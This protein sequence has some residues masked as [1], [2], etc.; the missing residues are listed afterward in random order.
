MPAFVNP[1]V[2][3]EPAEGANDALLNREFGFPA[4]GL[5]FF[6]IEEDEGVVADPAFVAAGVFDFRRHAE[7]GADVADALVDLH[8]FGRA[9]IVDLRVVLGVAGG[10]L[11]RD[12]ED[13]VYAVLDV[14]VALALGAVAQDAKVAR[15][16]E[17]L[18]VKIENVAVRVALAEDGDEPENVGFVDLAT[19]SVGGDQALAGDFAGTVERGLDREK[20]S[21]R[22]GA[23]WG[24]EGFAVSGAGRG[25]TDAFNAVGAHGF[26]DVESSNGVLLEVFAGMLP[27]VF[28]VGV[29]GEMEDEVGAFHGGGERRQV[30]IIAADEAKLRMLFGAVEKAFLAGGEI[31]PAGDGG[32]VREKTVGEIGANETG[33]TGDEDVIERH[34]KTWGKLNG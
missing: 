25:E 16:L 4:R 5:N 12:V 1:A 13:G 3:F 21:L 28:D 11:A 6:G 8:V 14:E 22:R 23:V 2:G 18:L 20:I 34:G 7:G 19:F 17:E 15:M 27:A 31:I 30:E 9:E 32:A 26:E 10:V 29:G 24:D 33:D